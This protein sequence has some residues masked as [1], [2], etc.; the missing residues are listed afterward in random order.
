MNPLVLAGMQAGKHAI[1]RTLSVICVLLV[2]AGLYW[3]VYR[4]FIK[5]R[6]SESYQQKAEQI[7]NIETNYYPNKKVFGLGVTIFGF[8]IGISKYDYSKEKK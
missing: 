2:C 1:M 8:D 3:A 4:Q 7:T 5:P 6:P